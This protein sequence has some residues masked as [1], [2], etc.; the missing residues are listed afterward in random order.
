MEILYEKKRLLDAQSALNNAVAVSLEGRVRETVIYAVWS[1]GTTAGTV[2]VE[3]A[4]DA[5]YTGTWATVATIAWSAASKVDRV[6]I[7]AADEVLRTRIS[8]AV[9]GGTVSTYVVAN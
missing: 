6:V 4:H 1:A 9:A 8:V 2:V 7:P 3:A 5:A